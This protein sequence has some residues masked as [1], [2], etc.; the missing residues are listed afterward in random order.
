MRFNLRAIHTE[1]EA[2]EYLNW[3]LE[4]LPKGWR[5]EEIRIKKYIQLVV[6]QDI[7][8]SYADFCIY[9]YGNVYREGYINA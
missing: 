3:V 2:Y 9:Q 8:M 5:Q 7:P 6:E 1:K 4:E